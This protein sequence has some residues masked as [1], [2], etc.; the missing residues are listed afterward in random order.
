MLLT[1]TVMLGLTADTSAWVVVSRRSSV[2]RPQAL[3]LARTISTRLASEGVTLLPADDL[4]AC[5][6]K[7][8][9]LM[10]KGRAA[11]VD[12]LVCI[13]VANVLDD[14]I[15]VLSVLSVEEDG[16]RVAQT[17]IE[18][19]KGKFEAEAVAPIVPDLK[20]LLGLEAV[21]PPPPTPEPEPA[22]IVS[23]PPAL[24]PS[25][26]EAAPG[27]LVSTSARAPADSTSARRT[28]GIVSLA[29]GAAGLLTGAGFGVVATG[30]AGERARICP[31][32][33]C[34]QQAA[35][36]AYGRA[37]TAQSAGLVAA[38]IGAG[39][40]VLGAILFFSALDG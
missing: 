7:V 23:A 6:G 20:K 25:A 30:A 16:R 4:T 10:Q 37:A 36:D 22:P 12:A 3:E 31:T 21:A 17:Q 32:N 14:Q 39:L 27:P 26:V 11:K 38:G 5:S 19:A 29:L 33:P 2:T 15:V 24:T 40:F 13:D 18:G 34:S 1:M 8:P 28:L 9:C 35:F